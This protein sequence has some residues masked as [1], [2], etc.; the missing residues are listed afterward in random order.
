[1]RKGIWDGCKQPLI[2]RFKKMRMR[3]KYT[4]R[5]GP[6][7]ALPYFWKRNSVK[8]IDIRINNTYNIVA[9]GE[10]MRVS[11]IQNDDG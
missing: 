7:A 5:R 9:R 6:G 3:L 4:K 1:M 8:M 10:D 2:K 11:E